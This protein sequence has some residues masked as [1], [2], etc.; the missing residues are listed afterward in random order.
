[1]Q[2][3]VRN[4]CSSPPYK[5]K[6][7][8]A[9]VTS[10][11]AILLKETLSFHSFQKRF[12][13]MSS[14]LST[15]IAHL[16]TLKEPQVTK[17]SHGHLREW[18][19]SKAISLPSD[20]PSTLRRK[21]TPHWKELI[22]IQAARLNM[23]N[24]RAAAH[25]AAVR[26]ATKQRTFCQFVERQ[27]PTSLCRGCRTPETTLCHITYQSTCAESLNQTKETAEHQERQ[28]LEV[29]A[30]AMYYI[31]YIYY[32]FYFFYQTPTNKKKNWR[33]KVRGNWKFY[34]SDLGKLGNPYRHFICWR[35]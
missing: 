22:A 5:N 6:V 25:P 35:I 3:Q 24:A 14:F 19:P 32:S 21:G 18:Q 20:L 28:H 23:H 30:A 11:L 7:P 4:K 29:Q 10:A 17:L 9:L 12:H 8:E 15:L 27:P 33:N 26:K 16:Q 13:F 34:N 1:M 31:V 2:R